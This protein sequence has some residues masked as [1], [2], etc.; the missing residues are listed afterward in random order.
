MRAT[1]STKME[2]ESKSPDK[3]L[4]ELSDKQKADLIVAATT[5]VQAAIDELRELRELLETERLHGS[6]RSDR[7]LIE[8]SDQQK[9]DL[10]AA[11]TTK[12]QT[13]F[14]ELHEARQFY[15]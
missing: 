2:I 3:M 15:S 9:A 7:M 11:A 8:L 13:A 6:S 4:I 1:K 12:L 5:K 10:I 14:E